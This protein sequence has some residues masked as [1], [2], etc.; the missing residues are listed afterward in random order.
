MVMFLVQDCGLGYVVCDVRVVHWCFDGGCVRC[1]VMFIEQVEMGE[2][3]RRPRRVCWLCKH[4]GFDCV[5][6]NNE[7]GGKQ[8][9]LSRVKG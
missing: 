9:A 4:A 8:D 5:L 7:R 2:G 3:S 6:L 1:F